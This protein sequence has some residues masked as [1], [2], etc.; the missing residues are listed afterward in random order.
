MKDTSRRSFFRG[1]G[2]AT[3][4]LSSDNLNTARAAF[5][6]VARL[7][8]PNDVFTGALIAED[9]ATTF[10]YNALIGKVIQDPAL[11]GPGGSA[12]NVTPS[13]N[14]GNVSTLQAA[15]SAE[16]EHANLLRSLLKGSDA[17]TD[18]NQ[19]FYFPAGTFDTLNTFAK[20]LDALETALIGTYLAAV[21]QFSYLISQTPANQ[22]T[23]VNVDGTHV[24]SVE[25]LEYF[26]QLF[27]SM[28]GVEA[29]HRALGRVI[30]GTY[31]ANNLS[32]EQLN[33]ITNV[34]HGPT[35]AFVAL[36]SFLT[37]S[38]GPAYNVPWYLV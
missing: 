35:S 14:A 31:P 2:A 15:L 1:L 8:G 33:G 22:P 32:Y 36:T 26:A 10:Y 11:A 13:G 21:R 16:I 27:A 9:L 17:A 37:P 5:E 38:T 19:T 18:P 7:D 28:G 4:V 30:T 6:D 25:E 23:F 12:N 3:A 34:F 20:M 24:F 29:E